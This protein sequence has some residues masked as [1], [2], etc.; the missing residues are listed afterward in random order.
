MELVSRMKQLN[1]H[2][3]CTFQML[4]YPV[5]LGSGAHPA[6]YP[7]GAGGPFPGEK[8]RPWCDADHSPPTIAVV[9]NE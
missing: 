6:S 3:R 5:S 2:I 4:L 8:A 9:K 7:M 1:W